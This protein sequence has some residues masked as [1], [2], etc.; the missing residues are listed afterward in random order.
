M[1]YLTFSSDLIVKYELDKDQLAGKRAF[2]IS[3][4]SKLTEMESTV[5]YNRGTQNCQTKT[6]YVLVSFC[7]LC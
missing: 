6:V 3:G 1:F 4:A 7:C 2:F 5:T